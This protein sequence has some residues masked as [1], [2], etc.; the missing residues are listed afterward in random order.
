MRLSAICITAALLVV[1]RLVHAQDEPEAVGASAQDAIDEDAWARQRY[2]ADRIELVEGDGGLQA[3]RGN[4]RCLSAAA[5]ATIL[6]DDPVRAAMD[7]RH[8]R[9]L[10][11]SVIL[12]SS[13]GALGVGSLGYYAVRHYQENG[14]FCWKP[15]WRPSDKLNNT[16][17]GLVGGAVVLGLA[18]G[19]L[20][21]AGRRRG[22]QVGSWYQTDELQPMVDEYN[23]GLAPEHIREA[24]D[25]EDTGRFELRPI[26]GPASL[27]FS[28]S[29]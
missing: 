24:I 15:C 26:V 1:P 6:S 3:C 22:R 5:L 23:S 20:Y 16:V 27:G 18:G 21:A 10:T 7:R 4:G 8:K 9:Q 13:A 25:R 19:H 14:W 17:G 12:W 11:S 28:V 29:Y 2:I